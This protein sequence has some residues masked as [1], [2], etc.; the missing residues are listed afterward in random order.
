MLC[1]IH[2]K[3]GIYH[4]RLL[5]YKLLIHLHSL[6]LVKGSV[7]SVFLRNMHIYACCMSSY[8]E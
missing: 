1:N 4:F 7:V 2:R 3:Y 8:Y 6:T 5:L